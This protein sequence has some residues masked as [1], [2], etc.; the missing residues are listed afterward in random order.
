[1]APSFFHEAGTATLRAM[2]AALSRDGNDVPTLALAAAVAVAFA[3]SS[4]VVLALPQLL[5]EFDTSITPV[6]WVI[7]A[8]NLVVAAL[9]LVLGR[10]L[11]LARPRALATA[12]LIVFLVASLLCAFAGT[13]PVLVTLR[14]VQGVGAALLLTAALPVLVARS[15]SQARGAALWVTAGA[16]GAAIGPALGGLLTELFDWRAIFLVQAPVAALAL[17]AALSATARPLPAE[18][19]AGADRRAVAANLGLALVFAALVGALFLIVILLVEI[20][21][22]SPLAA[23]GVVSVLPLATVVGGRLERS[24]AGAVGAAAGAL[25]L[26]AGLLGLALLPA[27]SVLLVIASLTLC[28]SA[29]GLALPFLTHASL[30]R[31]PLAAAGARSVGARHAGL[32]VALVLVAPLLASSIDDGAERA[33]LGSTAAVLDAP[34]GVVDKLGL[35]LA[36]DR[37]IDETP[38]GSMPD[39]DQAFEGRDGAGVEDLRETLV[40]TLQDTLTR[41]FR[42]SFALSAGFAL[43]AVAPIVFLRR[44]TP[45]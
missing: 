24:L 30:E 22:L 11:G 4:I 21:D 40:S 13:L 1:M 34:V 44:R 29:L 28:G 25:V 39:V 5:A 33:A 20:W 17:P 45:A 9:T 43:L 23:A 37:T 6:S 41:S 26:T 18:P 8:Y 36:L 7:T 15:G 27:T 2:R 38:K 35:A 14:C 10:R 42:S 16:V 3:D 32:V 12:G 19:H 31:G